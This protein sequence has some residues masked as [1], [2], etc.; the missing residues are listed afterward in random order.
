MRGKP[1]FLTN[2]HD[3]LRVHVLKHVRQNSLSH[4]CYSVADMGRVNQKPKSK[5]NA[6]AKAK[7]LLCEGALRLHGFDFGLAVDFKPPSSA[8]E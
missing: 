1:G 8:T 3:P 7:A 5:A 6:K 4:L 2:S